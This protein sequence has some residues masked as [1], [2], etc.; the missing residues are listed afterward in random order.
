[1]IILH[2]HLQPQIKYELFHIYFSNS[3]IIHQVKTKKPTTVKEGLIPGL[4]YHWFW[5]F[6]FSVYSSV[7]CFVKNT[8]LRVVFSTL[9]SVFG[10]PD[11]TLSLVFDILLQSSLTLPLAPMG[12]QKHLYNIVLSKASIPYLRQRLCW[13]YLRHITPGYN[14]WRQAGF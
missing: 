8:P 12:S 1:M 3:L 2:F 10:F 11:E 14:A 5:R 13:S 4:H 9:F 6:Y 7:F